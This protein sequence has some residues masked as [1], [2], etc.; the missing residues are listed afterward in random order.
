MKVNDRLWLPPGVDRADTAKQLQM[1]GASV[2]KPM[3]QLAAAIRKI[4]FE[5]A[6]RVDRDEQVVEVQFTPQT[7]QMVQAVK[8]HAQSSQATSLRVAM[9]IGVLDDERQVILACIEKGLEEL[10][11][12]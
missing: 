5:C 10:R 4:G 6:W 8:V 2:R 12:L 7:P 3:Q 11:Q 1:G 9:Q